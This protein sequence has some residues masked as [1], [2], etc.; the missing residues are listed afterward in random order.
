MVTQVIANIITQL[1][2]LNGNLMTQYR[3]N[4]KRMSIQVVASPINKSIVDIAHSIINNDLF[5]GELNKLENN[6]SL[7]NR[8]LGPN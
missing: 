6:N 2:I 3:A 8:D 4:A 1:N 7:R 5:L